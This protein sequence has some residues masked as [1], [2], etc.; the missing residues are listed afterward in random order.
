MA[1]LRTLTP[2][3]V[4]ATGVVAGPQSCPSDTP[5]SC[6]N[7]TTVENTCCFIPAGQ[8]LQTQFWDTAPATGPAGM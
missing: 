7:Q 2:L 1:F 6:H 5:L 3:F 8:L 4:L